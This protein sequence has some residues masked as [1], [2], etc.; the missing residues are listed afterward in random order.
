MTGKSV[1]YEYKERRL[2]KPT[3]YRMHYN[4]TTQWRIVKSYGH[5]NKNN[6]EE[7]KI[8]IKQSE[9]II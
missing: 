4:N 9:I 5:L 1:D 7:I 3:I 6:C 2:E 8:K